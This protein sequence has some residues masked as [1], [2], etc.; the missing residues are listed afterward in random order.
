MIRDEDIRKTIRKEETI[1]NVIRKR[2][3]RLSGHICRMNDNRLINHAIFA[4]IDGKPRS[5][6]PRRL[7]GP[8]QGLV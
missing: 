6:R 7:A 5:G 4:K 3:L 8:Y 1:T 2:K